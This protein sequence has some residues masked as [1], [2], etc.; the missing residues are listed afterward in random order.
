MSGK[1]LKAGQAQAGDA[2]VL[3]ARLLARLDT[4]DYADGDNATD[5]ARGFGSP[6]QVEEDPE[7]YEAKSQAQQIVDLA[8]GQ[9]HQTLS[10]AQAQAR[11]TISD[12][13][14]QAAALI[15]STQE[16]L[17]AKREA[18]EDSVR[19]Q[20]CT[21]YSERYV[22]AVTAL[23]AAASELYAKQAEYL[24]QIEQPAFQLVLAIARQLIG[25]E[26]S[27]APEFIGAMI[28]QAF[29]L[30]KPEQV[31]VV[32][33]NPQTFQLLVVDE[34]LNVALSQAGIMS[35]RVELAIDE[36][37]VP[38][39]FSMRING[40]HLDYDLQAAIDQMIE[41]LELRSLQP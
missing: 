26:L 39:Q 13:Q 31:A 21:E 19:Q 7:L 20:L 23:E 5:I 6:G 30:L 40:M 11:Q 34:M 41:H 18:L 1:V 32:S 28:A 15:Q 8:L 24:G 22:A 29:H 17:D 12:A 2:V 4:E 27:R 3:S 38:G 33:V 16:E 35:E 37:L 14:A 25:G 9:A 36:T 10:T